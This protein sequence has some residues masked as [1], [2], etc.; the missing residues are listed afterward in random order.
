MKTTVKHRAK[1]SK[2]PR[3]LDPEI[4]ANILWFSKF[5]PLE[6]IAIYEEQRERVRRFK[7]RALECIKNTSSKK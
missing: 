1:K 3:R 6:K 5:T 2:I 4:V 7:G